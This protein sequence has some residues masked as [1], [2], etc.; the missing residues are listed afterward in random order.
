[1]VVI[2][3]VV[4]KVK[5]RHQGCFR[6]LDIFFEPRFERSVAKRV[7]MKGV[8]RRI[9]AIPKCRRW[10]FGLKGLVA[11]RRRRP[12]P[13][14]ALVSARV[15][16]SRPNARMDVH[17]KRTHAIL[18]QSIDN[19]AGAERFREYLPRRSNSKLNRCLFFITPLISYATHGFIQNLG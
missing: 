6:W 10:R 12:P 19:T 13:R 15:C 8:G 16:F 1:M 9:K 14:S 18:M 3:L 7:K 17:K 4:G 5:G 11:K 2:E